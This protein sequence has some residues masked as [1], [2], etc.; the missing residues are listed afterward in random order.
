MLKNG[1]DL[2]LICKSKTKNTMTWMVD[3]LKI[4]L[5]TRNV[6]GILLIILFVYCKEI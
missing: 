6:Y 2:I 3:S 1:K 4:K 5:F